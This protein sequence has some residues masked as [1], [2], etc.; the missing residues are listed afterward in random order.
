MEVV[1]SVVVQEQHGVEE[2]RFL[3]GEAYTDVSH[4][5]GCRSLE[6]TLT[7]ILTLPVHRRKDFK[8]SN[9]ELCRRRE[10]MLRKEFVEMLKFIGA[11]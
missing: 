8:S 4:R 1:F 6:C 10:N 2:Y 7:P 11:L 3:R 5:G 9:A